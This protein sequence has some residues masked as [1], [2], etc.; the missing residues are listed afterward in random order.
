MRPYGHGKVWG[1]CLVAMRARQGQLGF[2]YLLRGLL[3]MLVLAAA[4]QRGHAGAAELQNVVALKHRQ[5]GVNLVRLAGQL[6]NHTVGRQVN[7]FGLV[8]AGNLPQLGAVLV[9]TFYL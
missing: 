5:E 3:H 4:F 9:V 6:K 8:D 2:T 7:D 1:Q